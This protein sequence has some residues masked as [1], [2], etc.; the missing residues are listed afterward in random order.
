MWKP[1][2]PIPVEST[3]DAFVKFIGGQKI[4]D[5]LSGSPLF[6][7][8]DYFFPQE[9]VIAELK[10]LDVDLGRTDRFRDKQLGLAKDYFRAGK[11]TLRMALGAE[12]LPADFVRDTVRLYRPALSRVAKKA[13][14][15]IKSTKCQLKL[16]DAAGILILVNEGLTSLKPAQVLAVL[17]NVLTTSYASVDCL[18]YLTLN[19]YV[20]IPGN[21]YANQ[22]WVPLYSDR[23]PETLP[24]FVNDLGRK[25]GNF[26]DGVLGPADW[27]LETPD[28][29]FLPATRAVGRAGTG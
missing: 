1:H 26:L 9:R 28:G 14:S 6:E 12:P 3:F 11:L 5:M 8:A 20:D 13:N 27:R 21:P 25:W 23:A 24:T 15:Q 16:E 2:D 19:T 17:A 10:Q 22:L 7:N 29:S 18:V 4:S